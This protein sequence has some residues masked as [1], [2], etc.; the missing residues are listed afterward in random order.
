MIVRFS[1]RA[2]RDLDEIFDDVMIRVSEKTA[3]RMIDRIERRASSLATFPQ[4]GAPLN[5][6]SHEG[7]RFVVERPYLIIYRASSSEAAVLAVL[8]GARDIEAELSSPWF[9]T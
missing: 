8:H 1:Q 2:E 9:D 5:V 3:N 4:R 6:G 7:L